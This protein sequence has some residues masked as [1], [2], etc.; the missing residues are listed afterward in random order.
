M[1]EPLPYRKHDG[2]FGIWEI[3][4]TPDG[5]ID[6]KTD[7]VIRDNGYNEKLIEYI[8]V[9]KGVLKAIPD[10]DSMRK[11]FAK[12]GTRVGGGEVFPIM[13][14]TVERPLMDY[15]IKLEG[16]RVYVMAHNK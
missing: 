1:I 13:A 12:Y 7:E 16:S 9:I 8:N 11:Y 4:M 5:W 15:T 3:E 2:W 14:F 6:P 10:L